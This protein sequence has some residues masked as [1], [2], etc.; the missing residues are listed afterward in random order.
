MQV[1]GIVI[2]DNIKFEI[3]SEIM[4]KLKGFCSCGFLYIVIKIRLFFS[5]DIF[6]IIR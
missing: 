5:I 6:V 1:N 4:Y 3:V 2:V